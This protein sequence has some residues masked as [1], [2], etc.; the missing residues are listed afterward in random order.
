[1]SNSLRNAYENLGK[2]LPK[3][4]TVL[5]LDWNTENTSEENLVCVPVRLAH[6]IRTNE[7][8]Y[9][10]PEYLRAVLQRYEIMRNATKH[11]REQNASLPMLTAKRIV[12]INNTCKVI[13]MTNGEVYLYDDILDQVLAYKLKL[14]NASAT[15]L[16]WQRSPRLVFS[17][18]EWENITI[19]TSHGKKPHLNSIEKALIARYYPIF[20][21]R[22]CNYITWRSV[23]N[24][25][26]YC[27]R[28]NIN[29][30]NPRPRGRTDEKWSNE[31]T[32][33]LKEF[34][35]IYGPH[36]APLLPNRT[37]TAIKHRA[38]LL[39]LMAKNNHGKRYPKLPDNLLP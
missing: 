35:P 20:S 27:S 12:N 33:I 11:Y 22:I 37:L 17:D 14:T 34:Y 18:L 15:H 5:A 4:Y 7:A 1:M 39:G 21:T 23:H 31:E 32:E 25:H 29:T 19:D 2:T 24:M 13:E 16:G 30:T 38:D 26:A 9:H 28:C 6:T 8:Y 10:N 36:I 3:G